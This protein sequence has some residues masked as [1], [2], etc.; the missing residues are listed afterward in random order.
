[1]VRH[2]TIGSIGVTERRGAPRYGVDVEGVIRSDSGG[3]DRVTISNLSCDG[4]RLSAP[5]RRFAVGAVLTI[6]V[7]PVGIVRARVTRRVGASHGIRFDESLPPAALDH[8]RLFLS[9]E[10]ALIEERPAA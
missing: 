5:G 1:M 6:A 8:I 4:C 3:E 10:P 7:G 9:K 2:A